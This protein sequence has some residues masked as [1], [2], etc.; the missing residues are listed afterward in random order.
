MKLNFFP[1]ILCPWCLLQLVFLAIAA[2][3][4]MFLGKVCK[5][6]RAERAYEWCI[7]KLKDLKESAKF[8]KKKE[9]HCGC[10]DCG[11]DKK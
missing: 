10:D 7:T 4:L 2:L 5:I 11:H 6:K 1:V 8:W 9:P 3:F